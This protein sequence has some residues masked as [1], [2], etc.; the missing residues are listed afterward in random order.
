MGSTLP[1]LHEA[2]RANDYDRVRALLLDQPGAVHTADA[3]HNRAI[4]VAAGTPGINKDII[5]LLINSA[6]SACFT[7]N[8][9]GEIPLHC[10]ARSGNMA[11]VD[12]L[13]AVC[14]EAMACVD[15]DG[16][17]P[18]MAALKAGRVGATLALLRAYPCA[19]IMWDTA[20]QLPL[21]I[22]SQ[23]YC[24]LDA[25]DTCTHYA[26]VI[27]AVLTLAPWMPHADPRMLCVDD[28]DLS[29]LHMAA[30][31]NDGE[32]VRLVLRAMP[33]AA[34]SPNCMGDL[35][36][37]VAAWMG[38]A[39][40]VRDMLATMP[41]LTHA[42]NNKQELP[43]HCAASSESE[44]A[45]SLL[46]NAAPTT[47]TFFMLDGISPLYVAA[48]HG[49]LGGARALLQACPT[50]ATM[51]N[52]NGLL[53]VYAAAWFGHE[54]VVDVL[55]AAAPDAANTLAPLD[56]LNA[57]HA[58]ACMCWPRAIDVLLRHAPQLATSLTVDGK[59][60]VQL[61]LR[62]DE[63][64]AVRDDAAV[65]D[66]IAALIRVEPEL[67]RLALPIRM[68]AT[69]GMRMCVS[70]LVEAAPDT[71]M[72]GL[73]AALQA[74]QMRVACDLVALVPASDAFEALAPYGDILE[75]GQVFVEAIKAHVPLS[76]LCWKQVPRRV[77]G[78]LAALP[79]VM[80][81][82]RETDVHALVQRLGRRDKRYVQHAVMALNHAWPATPTELARRVVGLA[83]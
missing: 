21:H 44:A 72:A 81:K 22:A 18:L 3:E 2:V 62:R 39:D 10:A 1:P 26:E 37:H 49:N 67:A 11:A 16:S 74:K 66:A 71:A 68:A 57:L 83:V 30:F 54:G 32:L 8:A 55:M 25:M 9:R 14:Q 65:A 61:A 69:H 19:V 12:Q 64:S 28:G 82:G 80:D 45:V 20:G 47:A 34:L 60:A 56:G 4:H 23:R 77:P 59:T 17:T 73:K 76:N 6:S 40:I 29:V 38:H 15:V 53:P 58:A 78:L 46:V 79:T 7:V 35:P 5:R 75:M 36:V 48:C 63:C 13:S 31:Q 43:L 42:A 24:D 33:T 52:S 70:A 27:K 51:A 41:G 50:M